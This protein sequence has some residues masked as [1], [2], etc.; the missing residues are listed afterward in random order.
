MEPLDGPHEMRLRQALDPTPD[1]VERVVRRALA[2]P[3][4]APVL[5]LLPAAS[6]IA[7]LLVA[8]VL[9][10]RP[11]PTRRPAAASIETVGEVLVMRPKD[12]PVSIVSSG[13]EPS[14]PTGTLIVIYGGG[15]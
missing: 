6:L 1:A 3:R 14:S 8:A 12:G 13:P 11:L 4:P 15:Q 2:A 9:L 10:V 7:A 5:R